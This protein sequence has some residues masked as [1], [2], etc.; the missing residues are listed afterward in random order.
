MEPVRLTGST[1]GVRP[2]R[3]LRI[4]LVLALASVIWAP[5]AQHAEADE[6]AGAAA[7]IYGE[8]DPGALLCLLG[9][10]IAGV[11]IVRFARSRWIV[12]P[13]MTRKS[14]T[15]VAIPQALGLA[16]GPTLLG[17]VRLRQ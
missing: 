4:L 2:P 12:E 7:A 17:P 11:V 5:A 3:T 1:L 6:S 15:W 16:R 13:D 14:V 8:C 10:M 9:A